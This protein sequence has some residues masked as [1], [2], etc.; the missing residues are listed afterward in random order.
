MSP[1]AGLSS[2][3]EC[4][5]NVSSNVQRYFIADEMYRCTLCSL[6]T[7]ELHKW[8]INIVGLS[9]A[10]LDALVVAVFLSNRQQ[11]LPISVLVVQKLVE[12]PVLLHSCR[13]LESP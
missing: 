1:W 7:R 2:W 3:I 4:Y 11:T 10:R 12:T 9:F 13:L 8:M 5:Y 6:F